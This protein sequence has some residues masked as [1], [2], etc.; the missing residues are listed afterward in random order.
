MA[1]SSTTPGLGSRS[2]GKV[3]GG[4]MFFEAILVSY[5]MWRQWNIVVV[6]ICSAAL[7]AGAVYVSGKL[8]PMV[9][10]SWLLR[11]RVRAALP[12]L[13]SPTVT[14]GQRQLYHAR[15]GTP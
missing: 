12:T 6:V 8:A 3:I 10:P 15:K 2:M 1:T 14:P 9:R 5:T 4:A 7:M 11:P 13:K